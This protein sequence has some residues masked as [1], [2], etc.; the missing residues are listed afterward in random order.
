L[1]DYANLSR[2]QLIERLQALDGQMAIPPGQTLCEVE[3][4]EV[5]E[6]LRQLV[7]SVDE[8]FWICDVKERRYLYLS[9][10]VETLF[11]APLAGLYEDLPCFLSVVHP[12]DQKSVIKAW[13]LQLA[14]EHILDLEFRIQR[15]P[16]DQR[17]I[18]L[19]RF[20]IRD[21]TGRIYRMAG[22]ARDVT[23]RR[24]AAQEYRT[25][26]QASM[27]SFWKV[28]P[29][30][31]ILDC[32]EAACAMLG[33]S[34]EAMLAL[35]IH[36]I[37]LHEDKASAAEH[38]RL[39]IA[40]GHDRFEARHRHKDGRIIDV[41]VSAYHAPREEG[42][43]LFAFSRDITARN[44]AAEALRE[45]EFLYRNLFETM[46]QGVVYHDPSGAVISANCAAAEILGLSQDQLLGR[47]CFDPRWRSI[48][49]DGSPFP[50]E[51]HPAME[52]LRTG[53]PVIGVEMGVYI[54][55][56]DQYRWILIDAMPEFR[57][58]QSTLFR[59]YATLTD[60][61]ERKHAEEALI[62][63]EERYRAVVEDQTDFICRLLA[64][65]TLTFVNPVFCRFFGKREDELLGTPWRPC[66][67]PGDVAMIEAKL[68]T[69]SPSNPVVVIENRV[70]SGQGQE[71]W[72]Q[73]VNRAFFD[74][75]G[76]LTQIQAV[77]RDITDRIAAEQALQA[78]EQFKQAVLDA[79]ST[80]VAV[81]DATG[82]IVEVN[83]AWR[84]FAVENARVAG[85]PV[86]NSDIGA[87]YLSVCEAAIG[88]SHEGAR[89]VAQGIRAVL[90]GERE[91][92]QHEYPCH[93]PW[94]QRWFLL[95]VTP[96]KGGAGGVVVS[97]SD[98]TSPRLLAEELRQSEARTRSILRAAPV[99][100]GML[101]DRVFLDVNEGMTRM[102]GYAAEELVGQS[103]RLL[104]LSQPEF[105]YV[106]E[107]KYRQVREHGI[108][109]VETRWR[110]KDGTLIDV[111]LSSAPVV[112]GDLSQGVTFT[113]K[114]ITGEKR[115][116]QERL[117][118]ETAQRNA[119]VREVHHRIKNN[120]QGVIG[121]LRQHI[122]VHPDTRAAIEVAIDQI[123]TI[124]VVHGLQ[125]R[126]GQY[127]LRLCETLH[128][129]NAATSKAMALAPSSIDDRRSSD[130]WLDSGAAVSVALIL[131]ELLHNA[132]KHGHHAGGVNIVLTGGGEHAMVRISNPG[133][134]LPPGFD[135][136][137][138][139][140][141]G[142]GLDL[143]R[144]LLPR[145][146][147]TLTITQG[148]GRVTA[149]F[150]VAP[151]VTAE[152]PLDATTCQEAK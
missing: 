151:P 136:S 109:S 18:R 72:M 101:V 104:Y 81:L 145:R 51:T 127:E 116:E 19:R 53:R 50:G 124:A 85:Q 62:A 123:S 34:R 46:A 86:A 75:N 74:V 105:D 52:V 100:I 140:G 141:C 132:L 89:T 137:N 9:P 122:S 144:T 92:Y 99:G 110:R 134:P 66:A 130:I 55:E 64:D 32:N 45:N 125:S 152:R 58:G 40:Q 6:Y 146:G 120:L 65:G 115:A 111:S 150:A 103:A 114:D 49:P 131:N 79:V 31:R 93:A 119:L 78:A 142:T 71:R 41:E 126:L 22:V 38:I 12:E 33:Y 107:E 44:E 143:V 68:A 24:V 139:T 27:D 61:T 118:H 97:H 48:H 96:L 147:A 94:Q 20:P 76:G 67:H 29:D 88:I 87:N 69:L 82:N 148:E 117:A 73:F 26:I 98:I 77:A 35:S 59:V 60:I 7:A 10:A 112:P 8:A 23:A 5:A 80:Q 128:A 56:Q 129:V 83:A 149:E 2:E 13:M 57:S 54:P 108:G 70:T 63:S 95:S 106:G 121:L 138:G 39:V 15:G 1:N 16:D 113:A 47:T 36:D 84:R 17:W 14:D 25:I 28:G 42:G 37:D 11:G 91:F 4:H 90:A 3:Q 30:G 21:T 133:G 135:L 102:T 43:L